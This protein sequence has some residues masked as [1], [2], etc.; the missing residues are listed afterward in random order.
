MKLRLINFISAT[1]IVLVGAISA[2]IASAQEMGW[3]VGGGFGSSDDAVLDET[4][5]ALKLFGGYQ[6]NKNLAAEAAFVDLGEF[7]ALG[8]PNALEQYGLAFQVVGLVPIGQ[9]GAFFGKAGLFL[10][11]VDFLGTT[12]D[13]GTSA[14][15]GVG[16]EFDFSERWGARIEWERFND[17]SGGDVDLISGSVVYRFR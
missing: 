15:F 6:F 17:I 9:R 4:A 1:M 3:Y 11:D 16:G 7:D 2:P 12:V 5:S 14:A 8:L 13:D 10:W